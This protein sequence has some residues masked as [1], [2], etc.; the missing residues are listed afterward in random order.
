MSSIKHW[1]IASR[2][3]TLFASFAPLIIG[4][5]LSWSSGINP[6]TAIFIVIGAVSIQIGTNFS[7]D[8]FDFKQG[9]D[10]T[11]RKG[12]E[13]AVQT[14]LISGKSM[15]KATIFMFIIAAL[16]SIYLI[17]IGGLPI[18][19]IAISSIISGV[20]YTAGPYSLAYLGIADLFA[21]AFFGPIAV[22]GT[23][24]LLTGQWTLQ[25]VIVG[26]I[27][28]FFSMGLLIVNNIRDQNEDRAAGKKTLT[29]RFGLTFSRWQY[30]VCHVG[31]YAIALYLYLLEKNSS[32]IVLAIGVPFSHK[33]IN[34]TF[35]KTGK[36]LN[37][38]LAKTAIMMLGMSILV[39]IS[40]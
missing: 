37:A 36:A 38:T 39:S 26:S 16:A 24:Y 12:P 25:S 4:F 31:V 21:F 35:K 10:T 20:L 1:V 32:I 13:R 15:K 6:I 5:S 27:P 40:L 30:I 22:S 33:L 23:A 17:Y 34:D 2:P 19:I 3:K 7:N 9:A 28:G 8:Y 29:V 14:G 11:D 18:L